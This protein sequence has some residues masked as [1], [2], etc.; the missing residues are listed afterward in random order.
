MTPQELGERI[1]RVVREYISD[2]QIAAQAAMARA[3]ASQAGPH[4]RR[5]RSQ[6]PMPPRSGRNRRAPAQVVALA[7][8]FYQ[9]EGEHPGEKMAVLSGLVG[10]TARE[11]H[12]SV[13]AL[14]SAGRLR[15]VGS[16]NATRYF[17]LLGQAAAE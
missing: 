13:T 12:L 5:I 2:S 4:P 9:A 7:E 1:E 16:R 3:F 10:S 15:S 14:K 6:T 17:P 8:H 11:L